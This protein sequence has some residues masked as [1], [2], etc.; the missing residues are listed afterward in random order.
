MGFP[1]PARCFPP[2]QG[3]GI[4]GDAFCGVP[5]SPGGYTPGAVPKRPAPCS[6]LPQ[7]TIPVP[8][9]AGRPGRRGRSRKLRHS[10]STVHGKARYPGPGLTYPV[11]SGSLWQRFF[12]VG[13]G[14]LYAGRHRMAQTT[15]VGCRVRGQPGH[16]RYPRHKQG[17]R[18]PLAVFRFTKTATVLTLYPNRV[19][20]FFGETA[21]I[22]RQHA[23]RCIQHG[24]Q[25]L[26]VRVH[27]LLIG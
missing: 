27:K 22:H 13:G 21:L 10:L 14:I 3:M 24:G 12:P 15:P 26:L 8:G 1:D 7:N 18:R 20:S 2:V 23:I 25:A 16:S 6:S 17:R 19:R 11:Q 4:K 9:G 5:R